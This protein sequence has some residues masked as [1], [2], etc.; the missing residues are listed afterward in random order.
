MSAS[1][2]TV[3]YYFVPL[4]A[5]LLPRVSE[6]SK[7]E[8]AVVLTVCSKTIPWG[9]ASD[10]ISYSQFAA[11]TG[12]CLQAIADG[13]R[14]AIEHGILTREPAPGGSYRYALVIPDA[15]RR[16]GPAQAAP[17][18]APQDVSLS[19]RDTVED[20][21][22]DIKQSDIVD[23]CRALELVNEDIRRSGCDA[24]LQ[25]TRWLAEQAAAQG[26]RHGDLWDLWRACRDSGLRGRVGFFVKAL[27]GDG[28]GPQKAVGR[29]RAGGT[30]GRRHRVQAEARQALEW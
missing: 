26:L 15:E 21:T 8:L 3:P 12:L 22:R 6:M 11:A 29:G 28:R 13:I 7:A 4:P 16:V 5:Y 14:L 27:C 23:N 17:S 30:K 18:N 10:I 24:P 2:V 20:V 19:G 9:K 1:A 25:N